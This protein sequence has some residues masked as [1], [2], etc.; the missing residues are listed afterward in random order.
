MS[1]PSDR[2]ADTKMLAIATAPPLPHLLYQHDPIT[3]LSML[4]PQ[5]IPRLGPSSPTKKPKLSL[6]TSDLVPTFHGT[7]S[8]QTGITSNATA[9]PT[10]LNTFN[11]TFDLTYRPSPVS[12]LSSPG[13]HSQWK[14]AVHPPSPITRI[15]N[16]PYHLN[17]PFGVHPILK[18]SPLSG[19]ARRPSISASPRVPGRREFFP[20]PKKVT[21]RAQLEDEIITRQYTVRHIDLSS[22][23]DESTTSEVDEQSSTA[24]DEG[25]VDAA[26]PKIRVDEVSVRGRRKRKSVAISPSSA[27]EVGRG[28]E[29]RSRSTS[30]RRSKRKRRK[31]EWTIKPKS[32]D[33][34][35]EPVPV[36]ELEDAKEDHAD[37]GIERTASP[38]PEETEISGGVDEDTSPAVAGAP[39]VR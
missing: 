4:P 29:E 17:L 22:S 39:S 1:G 24:N 11:N 34:F 33:D 18:N 9:T 25:D 6:N 28:R 13:T 3:S 23:E 31:W 32:S 15:S 21:F 16:Q 7:V 30:T 37:T 5:N 2:T 38:A 35:N 8:R 36:K 26:D 10:T 14:P 27:T 19:D 12:T 20:A